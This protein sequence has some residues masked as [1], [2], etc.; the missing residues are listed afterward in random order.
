MTDQTET[1]IVQTEATPEVTTVSTSQAIDVL[2]K[3]F[4]VKL[5]EMK[6]IV[7]EMR[8]VKKEVATLERHL[9]KQKSKKKKNKNSSGNPSGFAIARPISDELSVFLGLEK[10]LPI[11]RTDV[12]KLLTKYIAEHDLKKPENKRNIL[13][14]GEHGLKFKSIL[15][16]YYP[17]AKLLW[18]EPWLQARK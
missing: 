16:H 9:E 13:L 4:D 2:V 1:P 11:A 10:G 12:T 8:T 5:R 15:K 3:Q 7:S 14:T 18:K 17:G 6:S